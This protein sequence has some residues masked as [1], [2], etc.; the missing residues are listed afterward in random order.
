MQLLLER[1][2]HAKNIDITHIFSPYIFLR[3]V[4]TLL[5]S[6]MVTQ[7]PKVKL[8][9]GEVRLQVPIRKSSRSADLASNHEMDQHD[10]M[11]RN[12][13]RYRMFRH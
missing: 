6:L 8:H 10:E 3:L 7:R 1:R 13:L 11:S 2:L 4:S 9:P 12:A 5:S